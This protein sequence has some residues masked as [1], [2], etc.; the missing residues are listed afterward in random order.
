MK[1][2][3]LVAGIVIGCL[4]TL[5]P[6]WGLIGTVL[7]MMNAFTTLGKQGVSDPAALSASVG[8]VLVSTAVGIFVAPI[9]AIILAVCIVVLVRSQQKPPALPAC[10]AENPGK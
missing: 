1:R 10:A 7:G 2:G 3:L 5:G 9:G 6:L 8:E 4:L